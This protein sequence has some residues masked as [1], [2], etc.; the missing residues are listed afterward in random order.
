VSTISFLD[1]S[2]EEWLSVER[3]DHLR[4]QL[5]CSVPLL[6]RAGVIN[7]VI[8]IWLKDQI[9]DPSL[10]S[11][12]HLIWARN[13]WGHRL[14]SLFLERKDYLDLASCK[15]LRVKNQGL[16]LE[17]YHRLL[18]G[19]ESFE[20][21][22]QQHGVGKE[23]FQGGL[24]KSQPLASFPDGLAKVLCRLQPGEVSKPLAMGKL[25]GIVQLE[26]FVPAVH[27]E[28]SATRLLEQEFEQWI[29]GMS[30]HLESLVS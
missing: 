11:E 7:K 24:F 1:P 2:P 4:E 30:I 14:D 6:N 28:E 21:L 12:S 29:K 23:R 3:L 8:V 13:Q 15:L 19:E 17:L 10:G 27:G 9:M 22:S 16:A 26:D 5:G 18:A 25:F 20:Q